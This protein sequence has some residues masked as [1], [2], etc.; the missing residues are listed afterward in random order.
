MTEKEDK[1][2]E[3]PVE[4]EEKPEEELSDGE[5]ISSVVRAQRQG[6][7][8]QFLCQ[9]LAQSVIC[10]DPLK[11]VKIVTE[12]AWTVEER[13]SMELKIDYERVK[14][15][16]ALANAF[17][18]PSTQRYNEILEVVSIPWG[19]DMK[20][21]NFEKFIR[22]WVQGYASYY[23]VF[24]SPRHVVL[25]KP[26]YESGWQPTVVKIIYEPHWEWF[27]ES[28]QCLSSQGFNTLR[29]SF[30]AWASPQAQRLLAELTNA[31]DPNTYRDILGLYTK[32][33]RRDYAQKVKETAQPKAGTQA[34]ET[35]VD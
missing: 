17:L 16:N 18:N 9:L 15:L 21:E 3:E 2:E 7:F 23:P 8:E 35:M 19:F 10:T 4:D 13:E 34:N 33:R 1:K 28:S 27:F 20:E 25:R 30:I 14:V 12:G 29:N 24:L 22:P 5:F 26:T 31:V 6:T 11:R 32:S